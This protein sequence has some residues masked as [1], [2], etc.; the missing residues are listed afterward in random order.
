MSTKIQIHVED[1][2]LSSE[3][4]ISD[5]ID[6]I[7]ATYDYAP[8][9]IAE[10]DDLDRRYTIEDAGK[11]LIVTEY[12]NKITYSDKI[13]KSGT[14]DRMSGIRTFSI[15][16]DAS[17]QLDTTWSED[18]NLTNNIELDVHHS[19]ESDSFK[20][21]KTIRVIGDDVEGEVSTDFK[22][23][24]EIDLHVKNSDTADKLTYPS[25]VRYN[26]DVSGELTEFDG[27]QDHLVGLHVYRSDSAEKLTHNAV[28]E[29]E[30]KITGR[31]DL[32]DL[33]LPEYTASLIVEDYGHRHT[34]EEIDDLQENLDSIRAEYVA[35][36]D[37]K[38]LSVTG[39]STGTVT[40][41]AGDESVSIELDAQDYRV[42]SRQDQID[43]LPE[44]LNIIREDK[45]SRT[46][47]VVYTLD[48]G[49][50]GTVTTNA[51]Q[52][53]TISTIV[54]D[55]SH[56][57]GLATLPEVQ[58]ALDDL[59]SGVN[60]NY[61][62]KETPE[63]I[64]LIGDV[65][66]SVTST[67]NA[68]EYEISVNVKDDSH[69]H[70]ISNVDGLQSELD[71]KVNRDDSETIKLVGDVV[72]EIISTQS[73]TIKEI[74]TTVVDDS[75]NH[76]DINTLPAAKT[77]T[78]EL[79]ATVEND[80]VRK[81]HPL[82]INIEGDASGSYQGSHGD[83]VMTVSVQIQDS[84][85]KHIIS[86]IFGL[87]GMLAGF[88]T[89]IVAVEDGKANK[90]QEVE[91]SLEGDTVGRLTYH[92]EDESLV[93]TTRT[94]IDANRIISGI[95]SNDRLNKA[96][97][98]GQYGITTLTDNADQLLDNVATTPKG[99]KTLVDSRFNDLET[100]KIDK[101][102]IGQPNGVAPLDAN[103]ILPQSVLPDSVDEVLEF[104]TFADFPVTGDKSKIYLALDTMK[105][106][107]WS[108]SAY[109]ALN[110]SV[111][112]AET[113]TRLETKR[114][115]NGVDFDGT[116]DISINLNNQIQSGDGI[117][118]FIFYGSEA[119]TVS[120]DSTV[121]RTDDPRLSDKRDPN[122]HVHPISD[123]T[124]LQQKLDQLDSTD[125][126]LQ[127]EKA[128]LSGA[129][130]TGVVHT[131]DLETNRIKDAQGNPMIYKNPNTSKI[132]IK[133][134]TTVP[135]LEADNLI[136]PEIEL[137][138]ST[139][140]TDNDSLFIG[141]N[142]VFSTNHR[143]E[144][145]E[146][147]GLGGALDDKLS[148][149]TGGTIAGHVYISDA[150]Q[151]LQQ[152]DG[153]N[154]IWRWGNDTDVEASEYGLRI[155]GAGDRSLSTFTIR[156]AADFER[157]SVDSAG[158]LKAP[159]ID[160]TEF[161]IN[162]TTTVT[163]DTVNIGVGNSTKNLVLQTTTVD[164]LYARIAGSAYQIY[165]TGFKP[166]ASD[167]GLGNLSVTNKGQLMIMTDVGANYIGMLNSSLC[168]YDT[169][170]T[171]GHYFYKN[172]Q[173]Q[174]RLTATEINI[175][176]IA[177]LNNG[178]N[179]YNGASINGDMTVKN[180][181]L[182]QSSAE[183]LAGT[184]QLF[185]DGRG[186]VGDT[187]TIRAM[188]ESVSSTI[189][190]E[191][192]RNGEIQYS[193]GSTPNGTNTIVINPYTGGLVSKRFTIASSVNGYFYS[194]AVG[195]TTF[196]DGD[197]LI[198]ESA[199]ITRIY[200]PDIRLGPSGSAGNISV[201]TGTAIRGPG[202]TIETSKLTMSSTIGSTRR[203]ELNSANLDFSDSS[204]SN[205]S[206]VRYISR[207]DGSIISGFGT[208]WDG[209]NDTITIAFAVGAGASWYDGNL[210][211]VSTTGDIINSGTTITKRVRL[212]EPR[213]ET[214]QPYVGF[215]TTEGLAK[216]GCMGGLT[217]SSN[218]GHISETPAN[219]I[220]SVGNIRT[221]SHIYTTNAPIYGGSWGHTNQPFIDIQGTSST[222]AY[223]IIGLNGGAGIRLQ[224]LGGNNPS[225]GAARLHLNNDKFYGFHTTSLSTPGTLTLGDGHINTSGASVGNYGAISISGVKGGYAGIHF[226][227]VNRTLM[228]SSTY[229]GFHTGTGWQ[230]AFVNGVLDV[231]TIPWERL[232][233]V[234]TTFT[235]GSHTHSGHDVRILGN[236]LT[237]NADGS[238]VKNN[239]NARTAGMYGVYSPDLYDQ[240]WSMGTA[241]RI[242]ANGSG[243]G[244]LY[245]AA[246][247]YQNKVNFVGG[248][249]FLWCG[250][251]VVNAAIGDGGFW[252]RAN[253]SAYSDIRVKTNIEKI[254]NA[255]DKIVQIG[256]YTYN[257]TDLEDTETRHS[258]VIAQEVQKILPEVVTEISD[259][260]DGTHLSVNYS[261][262]IPLLIEGIK[263]QKTLFE[264]SNKRI[265]TLENELATLRT[266]INSL[267]NK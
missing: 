160:S 104:D 153:A 140:T 98:A 55:D 22:N 151:F 162:G 41:N 44:D 164:K 232:S 31:I 133:S 28:V 102:V 170:A 262:I 35:K 205:A 186:S 161:R 85:H 20:D 196:T 146:V 248:H 97:N 95:I 69:N 165:H 70:V 156:G 219:G 202:Y 217:V 159:K 258:G 24:T 203:A 119:K 191:K 144:I 14:A 231:G 180:R 60:D 30:G 29:L 115:I 252:A 209:L 96:N 266:L 194:D 233:N 132:D 201:N 244:N 263:E 84:S 245:G 86:N 36:T 226:S 72:G 80:Y 92:L 67:K 65:S 130:F 3:Q 251:G 42:K 116:E 214:D 246:Y 74:V 40:Y 75:H 128:N 236:R 61:V 89:R 63:T 267:I 259:G 243:L 113:A 87:E 211:R 38:T 47:Q 17:G 33:S 218:Y 150:K 18:D 175:T 260:E 57:H 149:S 79:A 215:F 229:Q 91:L 143:P 167:V 62:K 157:M 50:T 216:N 184:P 21:P 192:Y 27:S 46:E 173:V 64:R 122:E 139:L 152:S 185:H 189:T 212:L 249:Q 221:A 34:I 45:I 25:T 154:A 37:S 125:Q 90:R 8:T 109:I 48:G 32:G 241:Y 193:T 4:L 83:E 168:H 145:T 39:D 23:D 131:P 11:A 254:D 94:E 171:D 59:E 103:G 100:R 181:M 101:S 81:D 197:F 230:W 155:G 213:I 199:P 129:D 124:G 141:V 206:G 190:W 6:I 135:T 108:G 7:A 234:P 137:G 176:G 195:R 228:V 223:N 110:D 82:R 66:G 198:T 179:V 163:S 51:D 105:T 52:N 56:Q 256:G 71:S 112:T 136:A 111:S 237:V 250:N 158:L 58:Q 16:G 182:I 9:E 77:Y 13:S 253:M 264:E 225:S 68:P 174:N 10:M 207:N 121:V 169:A 177:H 123:I 49:V 26:G 187:L 239:T 2:N 204:S 255:L 53:V 78:D 224:F 138:G 114:K 93:L 261:G 106:Y 12:G 183:T 73:E 134:D 127:T 242:A 222:T 178:L 172:V 147:V 235:P 15:S 43:N 126:Q 107:R 166:N 240:I 220:Y 210:F 265:E 247:A 257:R 200:S 227:S 118:P 142:Q 54:T 120:V 188:R 1:L 99:V 117:S 88:Q 208:R 148:K 19:T 5:N 76:N 238:I